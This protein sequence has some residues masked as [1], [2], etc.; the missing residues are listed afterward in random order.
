MGLE[1][2]IA[3]GRILCRGA[4][5]FEVVPATRPQAHGS[6]GALRASGAGNTGASMNRSRRRAEGK[7]AAT[8][9]SSG[10]RTLGPAAQTL[11]RAIAHHQRGE[12]APARALYERILAKEPTHTE[13]L[14]LLA[15]IA[16]Q[17]G[18]PAAAVSLLER[19]LAAAPGHAGAH[20]AL[21]KALLAL[22]RVAECVAC[23][24]RALA[25]RPDYAEAHV[26]L[27]DAQLR[28]G[29]LAAAVAS[30]HR[31]LALEPEKVE[32]L[33]NLGIALS[34]KREFEEA[35][36]CFQR[37]LELAPE[38]VAAHNNLGSVLCE[39]DRTEEALACYR[40]ALELAP[41]HV[42]AWENLAAALGKTRR[43][44]EA[45]EVC[46]QLVELTPESLE[47]RG[48]LFVAL[49]R[50]EHFEEA[51]AVAR[52]TLTRAPERPRAH[53]ELGTALFKTGRFA[54]AVATLANVLR[55]SPDDEEAHRCYGLALY[56]LHAEG[57]VG[58]AVAAARRW[59]D[60]HPGSPVAQHMGRALTGDEAPTRAND[61]FVRLTFDQFAATFDDTLAG[62][63]YRT[64][65]LVA[66]L[67]RER[68]DP[69][70]ASIDI[71][72]AGCGTGLLAP[73]VRSAAR[74]L[75]GV[76]LSQGMLEQA[77]R[78]G[79]YDTL[80]AAELC[81]FLGEQPE[82]FD[83][84]VLC[85]VLNYF[86]DLEPVFAALAGS[87]RPGGAVVFT[88]ERA[89]EGVARALLGAHGRYAH[90]EAFVRSLVPAHGLA[91]EHLAP[92]TLRR[93]AGQPVVGLLG[94]ARA[95]KPLP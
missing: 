19:A 61:A 6:L 52:D 44:E 69:A 20:N 27:G 22:G 36:A 68:L 75:T 51:E 64:P 34:R 47:A 90:A 38:F 73:M 16:Q 92:A 42:E 13:A 62:L 40:R 24:E 18:E 41:E 46:R 1:D 54:P 35:L 45:I 25:L 39:L 14:R 65:E 23:H 77:R 12:L 83:L 15:I 9:A 33:C 57:A 58:D 29:E 53:L 7:R 32:V 87:L 89:P 5:A 21:G 55:L 84:V 66:S 82:R 88:V 2:D 93:E 81:T 28:A 86:G 56:A 26:G 37:A 17:E 30:Y 71:L 63:D 67:V 43:H 80:V 8:R 70:A 78:R 95:A 60:D 3:A 59:V 79:L 49:F 31:A 4:V 94:L 91:L 10:G 50:A 11:E 48:D 72:D 76:D 85:D 74:S